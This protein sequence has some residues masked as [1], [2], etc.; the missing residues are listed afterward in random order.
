LSVQ[1]SAKKVQGIQVISVS[2]EIDGKT[3]PQAQEAIVPLMPEGKTLVLDMGAVGFMSSAGLRM[4]LLLYRQGAS[5]GCT[6]ALAGLSDEIRDTMDATGF[7][8][9]F[10]VAPDVAAAI[11]LLKAA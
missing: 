10:V 3:A 2:G 7:L 5:K 8:N 6:V 11:A 9:F 1:V 4:M